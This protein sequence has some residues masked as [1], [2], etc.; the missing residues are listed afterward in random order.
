MSAKENPGLSIGSNQLSFRIL[1]GIL[2]VFRIFSSLSSS[3]SSKDP[4]EVIRKWIRIAETGVG[5]RRRSRKAE[6][7]DSW[8][9]C[10]TPFFV[11]QDSLV[12]P[13]AGMNY[14]SIHPR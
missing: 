5:G 9:C 3:S 11:P 14:R 8:R 12:N 2:E 4:S 10:E 13:D 1:F 6:E 7:G